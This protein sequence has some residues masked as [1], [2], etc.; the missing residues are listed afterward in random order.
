M[1]MIP[2]AQPPV[3]GLIPTPPPAAPAPEQVQVAQQPQV[4]QPQEQPQQPQTLGAGPLGSAAQ[5]VPAPSPQPMVPQAPGMPQAQ[6]AF[7]TQPQQVVSPQQFQPQ[8]Q[9]VAQPAVAQGYPQHQAP[10][11]VAPQQ[12]QQPGFPAPQAAPTNLHAGV[13]TGWDGAAAIGGGGGD[14]TKKFNPPAGTNTVIRF[15]GD[16]PLAAYRQHWVEMNGAKKRPYTCLTSVGQANCPLCDRGI[17]SEARVAFS[18]MTFTN[19]QTEQ[20]VPIVNTDKLLWEVPQ[21]V[22]ESIQTFSQQM[23]M[24]INAPNVFYAVT[25]VAGQSPQVFPVDPMMVGLNV[26]SLDMNQIHAEPP[27]GVDAIEIE[28]HATLS[29]IAAALVG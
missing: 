27:F 20:G 15:L 6:Q 24:P 8:V 23:G 4:F 9:G 29:Q 16:A 26:A 7:P 14:Y 3:P 28:T 10:Q 12:F 19:A 18:I 25:K 11:P 1:T 17:K 13:M 5:S 2:G 22:K 21:R